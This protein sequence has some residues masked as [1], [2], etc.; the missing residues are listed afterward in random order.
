MVPLL[1]KL[2]C[3]LSLSMMFYLL[4]EEFIT[5]SSSTTSDVSLTSTE[6]RIVTSQPT[7][8]SDTE[9]EIIGMCDKY[10]ELCGG[11]REEEDPNL[12]AQGAAAC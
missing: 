8:I 3:I 10:E 4:D 11:M 2:S 6:Q 9:K 7:A 1:S 5:S 12:G